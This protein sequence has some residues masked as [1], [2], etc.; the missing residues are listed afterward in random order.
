MILGTILFWCTL[1][2]SGVS[3]IVPNSDE[4]E[5][6]DWQMDA[7]DLRDYLEQDTVP[8]QL[9]PAGYWQDVVKT[10]SQKA[11]LRNWSSEGVMPSL[12]Y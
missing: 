3:P 4:E 7:D 6:G 2:L 10:D 12:G 11:A 5:D 9:P 1:L 8:H